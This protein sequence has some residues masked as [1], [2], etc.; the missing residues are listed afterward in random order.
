MKLYNAK[1]ECAAPAVVL[2]DMIL[3]KDLPTTAGSKMLSGYMS[4][5]DAEVISRLAKAGYA[6]RGK[7]AVGEFGID[8][9]GE[10]SVSG[11]IYKDGALVSAAHEIVLS[12]EVKA[13]ICLDVNGSVRRASA[14][15]GLVSVKPTY[16]TVSRFGTIPAACSGECVSVV[17]ASAAECREVLSVINGHDDKDGTSLSEQTCRSAL[18]A[19]K[20]PTRV[21]IIGDFLDGISAD[22][23]E[24][25]DLA[26]ASFERS[27]AVVE[28]ISSPELSAAR[29]A[30][31][32]LMSAETCNNVSRYDGVKYGYRSESFMG[33]DE[34]Y[35]KSRSEAF[36]ALLKS[37]IIYG[38]EALSTENYMKVY[39]K[40]LRVRRVIVEKL[41]KIFESY[42]LVLIP[43]TSEMK[44]TKEAIEACPDMAFTENLYTAPASISGFPAVVAGGVML[45]GGTFSEGK[46]LTA[47]ELI[48]GEGR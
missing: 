36:G 33:L 21:A 7:A 39:D 11:A 41:S 5:F 4:L 45:M 2:D 48:E 20:A 12:G 15:S 42:D 43:A 13:A 9:M 40:A 30:W 17:A 3:T 29:A 23:K 46:L 35:T 24:K 38:S 44:Y 19:G 34:L 18:E 37:V 16:G 25:L 31:N 27:G 28:T 32:I 14:Q 1:V 6:V 10:S 8:L 47:A 22:V 26:A